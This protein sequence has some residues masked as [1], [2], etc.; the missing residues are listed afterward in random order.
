MEDNTNLARLSGPVTLMNKRH[1]ASV[2]AVY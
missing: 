1:I 2:D